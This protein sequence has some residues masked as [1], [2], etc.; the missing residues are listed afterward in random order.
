MASF[1]FSVT[2]YHALPCERVSCS[3]VLPPIVPPFP[4]LDWTTGL[5]LI[6]IGFRVTEAHVFVP[7]RNTPNVFPLKLSFPPLPP[8]SADPGFGVQ[9]NPQLPALAATPEIAVLFSVP[10]RADFLPGV[11]DHLGSAK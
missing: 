7:R 3:V 8:R 10:S 9:R 4:C 6:P 11:P 5:P 1:F 2:A